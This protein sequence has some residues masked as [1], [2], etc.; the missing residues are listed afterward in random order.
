MSNVTPRHRFTW[1]HALVIALFLAVTVWVAVASAPY[2]TRPR[3]ESFIRGFGPWG[4]LILLGLQVAQILIAPIPGVFLPIL[5]GAL[6][7]PVVGVLIAT[8]GTLLGSAAAYAIGNRAGVP[9]LRRWIGE[10]NVARA[11]GLVGGSAGSRSFRSFSCPSR[12]PT[13]SASSPE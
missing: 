10:E 5:A 6:Y 12:P 13:R 1:R 3:L 2:F 11:Q 8:G 4:P 9:L 7:G